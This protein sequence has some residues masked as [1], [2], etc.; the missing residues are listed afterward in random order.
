[1]QPDGSGPIQRYVQ[2]SRWDEKS[3]VIRVTKKSDGSH[4]ER[5]PFAVRQSFFARNRR[6]ASVV[7][8]VV[9]V[10]RDVPQINWGR[11]KE[12]IL[13]ESDPAKNGE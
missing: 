6:L 4:W 9:V 13:R 10:G 7:G 3:A 5:T 8:Q 1:L 11:A 2:V 12:K